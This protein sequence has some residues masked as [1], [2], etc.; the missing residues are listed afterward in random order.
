MKV[1]ETDQRSQHLKTHSKPFRCDPCQRGFALR[2][3]LDRHVKAR[4]RLGHNIIY[5]PHGCRFETKRKDNLIRH[6]RNKHEIAIQAKQNES[7]KETTEKEAVLSEPSPASSIDSNFSVHLFTCEI[8]MQA[9]TAGNLAILQA[10]LEAGIDIQSRAS[11][12][13]TALHCAARAD[14]AVAV[15]YLLDQG[16][17]INCKNNALRVPLEEAILGRSVKTVRVLLSKNTTETSPRLTHYVAQSRTI[18]VFRLYVEYLGKD[19]TARVQQKFAWAAVRFGETAMVVDL[20]ARPDFD[21]NGVNVR[22]DTLL[23]HAVRHGNME[24]WNLLLA[25]E[26][27]DLNSCDG[28]S[29]RPIHIAA[30]EGRLEIMEILLNDKRVDVTIGERDGENALHLAARRGYA[31]IVNL[32]LKHNGLVLVSKQTAWGNTPLTLAAQHG[33]LNVVQILLDQESIDPSCADIDGQLPLHKA[34]ANG[35]WDIVDLLLCHAGHPKPSEIHVDKLQE[36]KRKDMLEVV[37]RLLSVPA[38]QNVNSTKYLGQSLLHRSIRNQDYRLTKF[39]LARE[40][41][42]V[43]S[44]YPIWKGTP[45]HFA[46]HDGKVE[47]VKLLLQHKGID[48]NARVSHGIT[49]LKVA[50]WYNRQ[51]VVDLLLSHGA[52]DEINSQSTLQDK[53]IND[54]H[55]AAIMVSETNNN[56]EPQNHSSF[57]ELIEDFEM[58][59]TYETEHDS[60]ANFMDDNTIELLLKEVFP[61]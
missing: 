56:H 4:H 47:G 17:I 36:H 26:K 33:H 57:N 30:F 12:G 38:F 52:M 24:V 29:R 20:L 53:S 10:Y 13:A 51:E 41:I 19:F 14:Q 35:Y 40:D 3:D 32:L 22:G 21:I 58:N 55:H 44:K 25:S 27:I 42:D 18:E 2:S 7:Q 49:A 43:N 34:A 28:I 31:E 16:A 5:C 50:K 15:Q 11:D 37:E 60:V 9:A 8:F 48:I 23:H 59:T 54:T 6:V 39:L 45:L 61:L 46:A 1:L